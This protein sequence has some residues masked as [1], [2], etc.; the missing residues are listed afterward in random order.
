MNRREFSKLL[1]FG[2][3]AFL[4]PA[5][6]SPQTSPPYFQSD[7]PDFQ[8]ADT[9]DGSVSGNLA[10][11][12]ASSIVGAA[13]LISGVLYLG[14]DGTGQH[15]VEVRPTGLPGFLGFRSVSQELRGAELA[16]PL[17][18]RCANNGQFEVRVTR[19]GLTQFGWSFSPIAWW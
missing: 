14:A 13:A 16:I 8:W 1:P 7:P 5:K 10:T 11:I 9:V 6:E 15:R 3:L 17:M 2:L 18:V 4:F 12:D 19:T